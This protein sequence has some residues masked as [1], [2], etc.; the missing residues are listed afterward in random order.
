MTKDRVEL[1]RVTYNQFRETLEIASRG[2]KD[3]EPLKMPMW[4]DSPSIVQ[5]AWVLAAEKALEFGI[6]QHLSH[7]IDDIG[8]KAIENTIEDL[9]ILTKGTKK[10]IN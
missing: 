5:L 1:G 6:H 2:L 10:D 4:E 8:K 3:V 9:N 7:I